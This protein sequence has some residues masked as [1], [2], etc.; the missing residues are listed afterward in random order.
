MGSE[1]KGRDTVTLPAWV[2]NQV[3]GFASTWQHARNQWYNNFHCQSSYFTNIFGNGQKQVHLSHVSS[4][5]RAE[6]PGFVLK[7]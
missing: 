5:L 7:M 3:D 1:G 6:F 4:Y 2:A